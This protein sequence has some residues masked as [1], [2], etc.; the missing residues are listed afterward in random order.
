MSAKNESAV[1]F[2]HGFLGTPDFFNQFIRL[3]LRDKFG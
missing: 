2:I 3:I 1:L